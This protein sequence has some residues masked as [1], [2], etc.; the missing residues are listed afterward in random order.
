MTTELVELPDDHPAHLTPDQCQEAL[1]SGDHSCR[2]GNSL[3]YTASEG[4]RCVNE[5]GTPGAHS[6]WGRLT[7]ETPP[8]REGWEPPPDS[9]RSEATPAPVEQQGFDQH[10]KGESGRNIEPQKKAL[11]AAVVE[12]LGGAN[13]KFATSCTDLTVDFDP[14]SCRCTGLCDCDN[15][16]GAGTTTADQPHVVGVHSYEDGQWLIVAPVDL[17]DAAGQ[18]LSEG[19]ELP[20]LSPPLN[21][22]ATPSSPVNTDLWA[23]HVRGLWLHHIG[24]PT[25]Q[26]ATVSSVGISEGD[27]A[28][29][30]LHHYWTD[31]TVWL[32]TTTA[33]GQAKTSHR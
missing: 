20:N 18:T 23:E 9:P 5:D 31:L 14:E 22:E 11:T 27:H 32:D 8:R 4:V 6:S 25:G 19:G 12:A 24:T 16:T 10:P 30:D 17:A 15:G 13:G 7:E 2:C 28:D 21:T 1:D 33:T 26:E 3:A 29:G